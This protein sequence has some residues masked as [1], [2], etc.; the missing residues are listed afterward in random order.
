M[1][2]RHGFEDKRVTSDPRWRVMTALHDAG[3]S[4]N[5]Y[6]RQAFASVAATGRGAVTAVRS[7]ASSSVG[8]L[9]QAPE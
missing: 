3:V 8:Q 7:G 5:A 9:F 4:R 2:S 6:A 1:F